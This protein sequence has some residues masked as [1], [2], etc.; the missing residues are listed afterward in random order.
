MNRSIARH[1]FAIG[2][3]FLVIPIS[4]RAADM[5]ELFNSPG[6]QLQYQIIFKATSQGTV[7][8][9]A[10]TCAFSTSIE[11]QFS[12][13]LALDMR[14]GGPSV[15][16]VRDA[17]HSNNGQFDVAAAQKKAMDMLAKID[18]TATWMNS[19]IQVADDATDEEQ[20]AAGLAY[21]DSTSG[22]A[23][24]AYTLVEDCKDLVTEMGTVYDMTRRTQYNGSGKVRNSDQIMLEIDAAAKKYLLTMGYSYMDDSSSS[25]K[26]EIAEHTQDKGGPPH[27]TTTTQFVN[28]ENLTHDLRVDDST[29]LI[30]MALYLEGAIDPAKGKIIGEHNLK[31][32]YPGFNGDIAGILTI[33]FTLTPK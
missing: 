6:W 19:G 21:L 27:D 14:T 24:L 28:L 30:G 2:L 10:G 8:P 23:K 33:R 31:A 3:I 32:H 12:K 7:T 25:V 26:V 17:M 1:F 18:N 5:Q 4:V 16:T 11:R 13:S 20:Q 29:A 15:S 9:T 22:T